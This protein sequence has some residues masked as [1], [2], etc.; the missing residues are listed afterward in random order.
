MTK[1]TKEE[2]LAAIL[3]S[4]GVKS[5]AKR[6]QINKKVLLHEVGMCRE[7]GEGGMLGKWKHWTAYEK[8]AV[9]EY[10]HQNHLSCKRTSIKFGIRGSTTVWRGSKST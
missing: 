5:V 4:E 10:M 1:Y 7:Y 6:M 8:I 2:K 9:L 3:A